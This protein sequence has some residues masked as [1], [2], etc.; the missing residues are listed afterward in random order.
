[1]TEMSG[2]PWASPQCTECGAPLASRVLPDGVVTIGHL[3]VEF[4]RE[5]DFVVCE[6]C[7]ATFRARDVRDGL[8]R[9]V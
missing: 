4:R 6:R 7:L 2:S 3:S 5:T 9:P 8:P 1:M